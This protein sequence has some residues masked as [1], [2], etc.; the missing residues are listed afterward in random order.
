MQQINYSRFGLPRYFIKIGITAILLP[1][2]FMVTTKLFYDDVRA[3]FGNHN[4]EIMK[5]IFAN[6]IILGLAF[7]AFSKSKAENEKTAFARISGYI[8]GF[9]TGIVMVFISP[10]FDIFGTG[11]IEAIDSRELISFML[12]MSLIFSYSAKKGIEKQ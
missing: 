12:I 9:A 10:V 4:V 1:L 7:I 11:E 5:A 6:C 2:A 3:Q 8:A